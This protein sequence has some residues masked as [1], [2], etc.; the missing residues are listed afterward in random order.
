MHDS[1]RQLASTV[2]VLKALYMCRPLLQAAAVLLVTEC[3]VC[4]PAG[5]HEYVFHTTKAGTG[6]EPITT[7]MT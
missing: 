7:V 3:A 5:R 6:P 4:M 1:S 2:Q